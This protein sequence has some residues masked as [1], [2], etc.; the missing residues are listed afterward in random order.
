MPH[1][2]LSSIERAN[3]AM[4]ITLKEAFL[5]ADNYCVK[6]DSYFLEYESIF[7]NYRSKDPVIVEIGVLDG[8][9][10]QMWR[11]YFGSKARI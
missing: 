8:G 10:L 3:I 4:S 11:E 2:T 1:L 9:S 6:L 7:E 5:S